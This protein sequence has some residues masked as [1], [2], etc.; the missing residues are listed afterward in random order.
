MASSVAQRDPT[1]LLPGPKFMSLIT[2]LGC[3]PTVSKTTENDTQ[4]ANEY[5]IDVTDRSDLIVAVC[6]TPRQAPRCPQ[7]KQV[8]PDWN[9]SP[10]AGDVDLVCAICGFGSPCSGWDWGHRAGF[11]RQWINIWGV[12]EGEAVPGEKLLNSLQEISGFAWNY[13]WCSKPGL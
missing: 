11:G 13:A 7:C 2:F 8:A 6:G 5:F 4:S 12:H 9:K 1:R 3:S 10:E